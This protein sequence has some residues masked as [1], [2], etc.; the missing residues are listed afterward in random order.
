[1]PEIK[2]S[3]HEALQLAKTLCWDLYD[4][5]PSL[6]AAPPGWPAGDK[7]EARLTAA[8]RLVEICEYIVEVNRG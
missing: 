4:D 5:E 6:W 8:K 7:D 3:P 2:L 1:M